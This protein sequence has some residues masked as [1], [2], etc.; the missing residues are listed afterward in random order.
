M[1]SQGAQ[2]PCL[3]RATKTDTGLL[4]PA[5][6]DRTSIR[7]PVRLPAHPVGLSQSR[8]TRQARSPTWRTCSRRIPTLPAACARSGGSAQLK[9]GCVMGP[10]LRRWTRPCQAS[11]GDLP[12]PLGRSPTFWAHIQED[13]RREH[14]RARPAG[15]GLDLGGQQTSRVLKGL[16]CPLF[17]LTT[18]IQYRHSFVPTCVHFC[19]NP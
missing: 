3:H 10:R 4:A 13:S 17:R 18:I 8:T 6:P 7:D 1:P 19:S 16:S 14:S 15:S 2:A 5:G 11:R 9:M 12:L